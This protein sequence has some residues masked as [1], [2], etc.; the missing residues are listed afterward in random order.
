MKPILIC[1]VC[2]EPLAPDAHSYRCAQGHCFDRSKYG[3]VNL[4]QRQKKKL[5]G[6]DAEMI[7]ARRDFLEDGAYRPLLD[8]A[9]EIVC[10][11]RPE[12]IA[13]IGCGEGWYSCGLLHRLS[14]G[15][16]LAGIDISPDALRYAAKRAARESLS[17]QTEWAAASVNRLPLGSESCD[18]LLN[19]FAPCEAAEFGRTLRKGGM[20]LRAV[21]LERHLWELKQAVYDAPYENRPVLDAPDG[22]VL[23]D[24]QRI[25]YRFP[26]SGKALHDL[27]A[28]TPYVHKTA[29]AHI[30][31]LNALTELTVSAAFGLLVCERAS[32]AV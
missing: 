24:V 4:L 15:T 27:F 26:V 11:I 28:M 14:P 7:R 25:E 16:A 23:R 5:R 13:D 20:L 29:P 8:A 3:Y 9:A 30:A 1:P 10:R 21:P 22:F 6:D 12:Q 19:F 31:R 32:G 17:G 18:L 2:G